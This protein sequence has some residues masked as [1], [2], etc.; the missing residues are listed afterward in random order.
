[1]RTELAAVLGVTEDGIRFILPDA[2]GNFGTK[3][4]MYVE[5]PTLGWAARRF[6]RPIKWAS[7]RTEA[8]LTD[9]QARDLTAEM[10]LAMDATGRFLAIRGSLMVN[11]GAHTVSY[12]PLVKGAGIIP[13]LYDI[14]AAG[15]RAR[16]VG[17][18]TAPITPFRSA[19]RPEA[20]WVIERLIDLAARRC[21]FDR[22][23][24]RRANLIQPSQFPYRSATGL[25]YDSGEY[26]RVM[27]RALAMGDWAGFPARR[28]EA[29]A[30]G[31]KRGIGLCNYIEVTSG[32]PR[33]RARIAVHPSG[34]VD[35]EVGTLPSGQGHL[36]AF[37]QLMVTWL[38]V[39]FEKVQVVCGDTDRTP[40]GGGSHSGRSMRMISICAGDAT[41]IL[42]GKARRIAALMLDAEA[43]ALVFEKPAFVDPATG[44]R[45]DLFEIARAAAARN[46]LPDELRAPLDAMSDQMMRHGGFPYG[47]HVAEVEVDPETGVVQLVRYAAVDDVGTAVNP[48]ILHG[49]THGGIVHG[50]GQ[51]MMEQ[52]RY[53]AGSGQLHSASFM[54]YAV[55]RAD[56]MPSF[57]TDLS[58][59]PS[60]TN[61]LG[62][63]AGGEGGTTGALGAIGN[64]VADALAEY[65]VEHIDMPLTPEKVWRAINAARTSIQEGN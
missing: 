25:N 14:P 7:D 42:L 39:D 45:A 60:P 65:G 40:V 4:F 30:R 16:G 49:Q 56:T 24:L 47:A 59:V 57:D 43:D 21:G 41:D 48:M 33:E 58:Q 28:A 44:R 2:G 10:E 53:E 26:E 20:I 18:N 17:S 51:A 15:I 9:Y 23:A 27:D 52:L 46:D 35:L 32:A 31:R 50:A 64:A 3:N 22:V 55:P 54:D 13:S 6:G 61:K 36:T 8:F 5:Y 38:G 11:V 63:R 29:A 37:A 1:M 12:V 62:V 34:T 19:G